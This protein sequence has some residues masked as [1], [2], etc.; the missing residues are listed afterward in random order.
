MHRSLPGKGETSSTH[1]LDK[2]RSHI[3]FIFSNP[4]PEQ[5][6]AFLEW[7]QGA[8]RGAVR[9]AGRVLRIEH[10]TRHPVDITQGQYAPLPYSYLGVCELSLDG[11]QQAETLIADI[12]ELHRKQP[13]AELPATWLYYPVSER[14][15]RSPQRSPSLLTLAFANGA[16]GQEPEFREW[17][18]TRHIRHAMKIPALVSGQCLERTL[19]QRPG[20]MSPD[21]QTIAFYEQEGTPESIIETFASLPAGSLD[22][23]SM[24]FAHFAESVYQPLAD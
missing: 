13:S 22:F 23:P 20:T 24:D 9:N 2:Q 7:Y 10:F 1:L 21:Y 8:Y 12:T 17:Y 3:L 5:G 11:A 15:G 6:P 4:A 18:A 16:K 14:V 19:F